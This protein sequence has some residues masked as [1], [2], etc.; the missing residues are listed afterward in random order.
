[1]GNGSGMPVLELLF[2]FVLV[3][4]LQF[5]TAFAGVVESL[6]I[7]SPPIAQNPWTIVT[8]I[9]AHNGTGHLLSNAVALVLF[10]WPVARATTRL[11][12]HL[13]FIVSGAVAGITQIVVSDAAGVLGASGAV[14][15]LFG[16]LIVG[17]RLS[18]SLV[19]AVRVPTWVTL[20]VFI[21]IAAVVTLATASPGVA[22]IAHFAGL[23][24]GLLAGRIGLL[25]TGPRRQRT[26]PTGA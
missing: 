22:L 21:V 18:S 16:Y 6:F 20:V 17:N 12:F 15:A 9:Y 13:F 1:M 24:V 25:D 19:Q 2:V 3:Y 14:F 5:I 4:V 7:L 10:G 11:R 23:L 26:E 8:S